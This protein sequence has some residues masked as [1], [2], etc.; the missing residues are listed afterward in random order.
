M[1]YKC[2]YKSKL[3]KIILLSNGK[4]L[5]YLC[6]DSS[7]FINEINKINFI[8]GGNLEI[9]DLTKKWLDRYFS[10]EN[11]NPKEVPIMVNGS[12]FSKKVWEILK[13]IPYG[14]VATYGDVAKQIAK[15][16]NIKVFI[17]FIKNYLTQTK[18]QI[19]FLF[20]DFF[21]RH[22]DVGKSQNKSYMHYKFHRIISVAQVIFFLLKQ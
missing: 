7:R 11:P 10:K 22:N 8:E 16:N 21:F 18:S 3:G 20:E 17:N 13:K 9:F 15:N 2:Y 6:F 1:E 12:N 5:T 4:E 19:F 14:E